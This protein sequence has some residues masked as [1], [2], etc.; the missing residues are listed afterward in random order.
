MHYPY[1]SDIIAKFGE[2]KY[3]K[4]MEAY[5]E[6]LDE[7]TGRISCVGLYACSQF[8]DII[9]LSCMIETPEEFEEVRYD[10]SDPDI[11]EIANAKIAEEFSQWQQSTKH[12]LVEIVNE[13]MA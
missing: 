4:F 6:A 10:L 8:A 3:S 12:A 7:I 1:D 5:G 11:I 2:Q 13:G 9:A